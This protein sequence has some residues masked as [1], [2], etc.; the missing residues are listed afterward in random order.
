[1]QCPL[2]GVKRTLGWRVLSFI[3]VPSASRGHADERAFH[4][5]LNALHRAGADAALARDLAYA[6]AGAQLR[7]DALFDGGIDFRPTE[8]LALCD[9]ALEASVDALPDYAA[10]KFPKRAAE[11]KHQLAGRGG[12]VDRL[13]IEVQID[14]AGLQRLDRAEQI[15]QRAAQAVD[16]PGHDHIKLAPLR[17]LEHLVEART[18]IA[19][20][21]TADTRVAVL[22]D[23]LPAPPLGDLAQGD[24]LVL[25][26]L[27]IG[28]YADVNCGAL[29]HDSPPMRSAP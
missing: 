26:G 13:L 8:L 15:D 23:H 2:L 12:G 18:L 16:R 19:A 7:L 24:D 4:L 25:D 11:L 3:C 21:G 22:L 9:R 27:L 14:A 6:F 17:I 10:L 5:L 1:M 20:L 29:L 28:R